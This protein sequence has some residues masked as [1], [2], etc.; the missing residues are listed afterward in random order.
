MALDLLPTTSLSVPVSERPI[1]FASLP[2]TMKAQE[3]DLWCWSAVAQFILSCFGWTKCQCRI[4]TEH[5]GRQSPSP[6]PCCC[7]PTAGLSVKCNRSQPLHLTLEQQCCLRCWQEF[8]TG[9]TA[10]L[11]GEVAA[12]L[13]KG[14]AVALRLLRFGKPHF[15]VISGLSDVTRQDIRWLLVQDPWGAK[16]HFARVDLFLLGTIVVPRETWKITHLYWTRSP[17]E[18]SPKCSS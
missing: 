3:V 4:A 17:V 8:P 16:Q 12:D 9:S 11:V 14:R 1:S 7:Q 10:G 18:G 6:P 2:C 5:F 15:M 13:K